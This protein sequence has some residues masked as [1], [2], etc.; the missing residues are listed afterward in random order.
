MLQLWDKPKLR[1]LI[2][3]LRRT[4][5][6]WYTYIAFWSRVLPWPEH[7]AYQNSFHPDSAKFEHY[8]FFTT[9]D[10]TA[11]VHAVWVADLLT[12][13]I[14]ESAMR[15]MRK[16]DWKQAI[17]HD[18]EPDHWIESTR[19]ISG[20]GWRNLG[21]VTRTRRGIMPHTVMRSLPKEFSHAKFEIITITPS[22]SAF[23]GCF[24]LNTDLESSYADIASSHVLPSGIPRLTGS[25]AIRDPRRVK[26]DMI[27]DIRE[28]WRDRIAKFMAMQLGTFLA[29]HNP[30]LLPMIDLVEFSKSGPSKMLNFLL[31]YTDRWETRH[32]VVKWAVY[33]SERRSQRFSTLYFSSSELDNEPNLDIYGGSGASSLIG[34]LSHSIDTNWA[35]EAIHSLLLH[36]ESFLSKRRDENFRPISRFWSERQYA[37][38]ERARDMADIQLVS[39]ELRSKDFDWLKQNMIEFSRKSFLG[40]ELSLKE[41]LSR[42]LRRRAKS[43]SKHHRTIVSVRSALNE[44]LSIFHMARI[45]TFSFYIALV[46]S[47]LS[48][49]AVL[50]A[51]AGNKDWT[52][53]FESL[54]GLGLR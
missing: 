48:F 1:S 21:F 32:S 4:V 42:R 22:L 35:F 49:L 11:K 17:L 9:K 7:L 38:A 31:E 53:F 40:E 50:L 44:S 36:Y 46:S 25:V 10:D 51:V 43:V 8:D 37:K 26:E 47:V 52:T 15:K 45:T 6:I 14:S 27:W 12:P 33:R 16:T 30:T 29:S 19:T 20:G 3:P 54:K 5:S 18:E 28:R 34:R 24:Y 2:W 41:V 23:V 39:E 13:S